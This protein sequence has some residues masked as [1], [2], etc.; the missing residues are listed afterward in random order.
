LL[1]PAARI[2]D[3]HD[4]DKLS[5]VAVLPDVVVDEA[6]EL[7]DADDVEVV[8]ADEL[9]PFPRAEIVP[10][11]LSLADKSVFNTDLFCKSRVFKLDANKLTSKQVDIN[12]LY[13]FLS[14]KFLMSLG[15]YSINK[16]VK[17]LFKS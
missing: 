6:D 3:K 13:T 14:I 4:G 15:D 10:F 5:F 16:K 17:L 9:T 1:K 11:V 12:D 8:V 7:D 2:S